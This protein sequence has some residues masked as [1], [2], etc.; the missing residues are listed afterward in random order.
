MPMF[1]QQL[2]WKV[3]MFSLVGEFTDDTRLVWTGKTREHAHNLMIARISSASFIYWSP[4]VIR[5]GNSYKEP[6]FV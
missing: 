6:D 3:F 5:R 4:V 2:G 1:K